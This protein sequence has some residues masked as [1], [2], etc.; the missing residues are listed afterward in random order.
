MQLFVKLSDLH[1]L[2]V[3]GSE[4]VADIKQQVAALDGLSAADVAM[5]C[6]GRPL[7]DDEI[8]SAY[9]EEQST[10]HVEVRLLGGNAETVWLELSIQ[11]LH[12]E[13]CDW[14]YSSL[15]SISFAIFIC[16]TKCPESSRSV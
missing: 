7:E 16:L 6:H 10:L 3:V 12:I 2:D 13:Q 8:I 11:V 5:Y 15:F 4:T 14:Y 1:T 9:A